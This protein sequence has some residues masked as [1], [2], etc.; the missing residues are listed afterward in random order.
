MSEGY[1]VILEKKGRGRGLLGGRPWAVRTFKLV[2]QNFEYYDGAKLKGTLN[3][4]GCKASLLKPSEA[5]NKEFPF[6][7][8]TV[9]GE[10]VILNG[11]SWAIRDKCVEV[12]NRASVNPRWDNPEDNERHRLEARLREL[13]YERLQSAA[14]GAAGVFGESGANAGL[15][16]SKAA[17]DAI[18]AEN[19]RPLN[20]LN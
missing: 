13:E 18:K 14:S 11:S 2:Q 7:M 3:A 6:K 19:V 17:A 15:K 10:D 1:A 9:E 4:K 12:L 16:K 8:V 20:T 5:D